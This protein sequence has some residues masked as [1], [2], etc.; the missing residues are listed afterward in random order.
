MEIFTEVG[1]RAG[2]DCGGFC[3]FCFYKNVDFNNLKPIGCKNCNINQ[4]GCEYCQTIIHRVSV[5]F[6][7]LSYYLERL[8]EKM[9]EVN[10][11]SLNKDIKL[12]VAG[13]ADVLNYPYLNEIITTIKEVPI[14]LHLGY[15]SGKPIKNKNI[16]EKVISSGVDMIS[17]SVFSTDPEMRRKWMHDETSEESIKGLKMF[18][19]NIDLNASAVVIPG[20][21]DKEQIFETCVD[22]E[23]WGAKSLTLR[24]FANFK[25]Q[26][27]ILNN[28]PII[29]GLNTHSYKEFKEL[30]QMIDNEFSFKVFGYPI[31]D[32]KNESPFIITKSENKHYLDKLG[33]IKA[34]ASVI[35]SELSAPYLKKI[36]EIIDRSNLIDIISV[37]KEI[38]DL[39][40]HEDLESVKLSKLKRKVIIPGGALIHDKYSEK[41]LSKDGKHR[42]IVRGPYVLSNPYNGEEFDNNKEELIKYE[43]DAFN[44]LIDKINH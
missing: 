32:P 8:K 44:A 16:A 12:I 43:L 26:G 25:N 14:L 33:V 11:D 29:K 15:T 37:D 4:I 5:P 42:R 13:G 7:P 3:E 6:I 36:L 19:E 1:G 27:L 22:L 35:T 24:R 17:F 34:E 18:C 38:A 2:I 30:V 23:E 31:Y 21:N 28:K 39:I 10:V 9:N 41:L 40:T 20:V